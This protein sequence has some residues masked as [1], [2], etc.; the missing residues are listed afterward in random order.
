M[1][2]NESNSY[3]MRRCAEEGMKPHPA[4]FPGRFAEFFIKFLTEEGDWVIDPLAG[5]N[6]TGF[7]A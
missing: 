2:N 1:G 5:S 4:R 6:T 3:Y 7:I